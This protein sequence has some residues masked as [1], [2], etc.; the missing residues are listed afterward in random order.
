MRS[1]KTLTS[2]PYSFLSLLALCPSSRLCL[3]TVEVDGKEW[4][5]KSLEAGLDKA[6]EKRVVGFLKSSRGLLLLFAV[7]ERASFECAKRWAEEASTKRGY[8][9]P[10][11]LVATKSDIPSDR[12]Q[13][14]AEEAQEFADSQGF[15]FVETSAA[16]SSQSIRDAYASII[17]SI[18]LLPPPSTNETSSLGKSAKNEEKCVIF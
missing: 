12:V 15:S 8:E 18:D 4:H 13:V 17:R 7:D 5:L 11:L 2:L 14:K 3:V 10:V 6:W 9:F 16:S 1:N